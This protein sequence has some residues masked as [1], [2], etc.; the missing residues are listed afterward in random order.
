MDLQHEMS[1]FCKVPFFMINTP[2]Q[3]FFST[4]YCICAVWHGGDQ[5]VDLSTIVQ[6]S[7]VKRLFA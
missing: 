5:S 3:G 7:P 2:A 4:N 1:N 6:V